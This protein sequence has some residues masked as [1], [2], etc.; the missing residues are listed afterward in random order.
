MDALFSDGITDASSYVTLDA[1]NLLINV[2]FSNSLKTS[3]SQAAGT[4]QVVDIT[5]KMRYGVLYPGSTQI[6]I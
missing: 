4:E 5:L 2:D 6:I 1:T 3:Y